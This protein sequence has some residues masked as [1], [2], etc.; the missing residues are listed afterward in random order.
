MFKQTLKTNTNKLLGNLKHSNH[1]KNQDV[2]HQEDQ[3]RLNVFIQMIRFHQ[4]ERGHALFMNV[5]T[6]GGHGRPHSWN[7]HVAY[8][9]NGG[10][11][12]LFILRAE[13]IENAKE[14]TFQWC[15]EAFMGER[16][17]QKVGS[18]FDQSVQT[19]FRQLFHKLGGSR[20]LQA[21]SLQGNR[22]RFTRWLAMMARLSKRNEKWMI[23]DVSAVFYEE[24]YQTRTPRH[25]SSNINFGCAF[26]LVPRFQIASCVQ[27]FHGS[28]L[29]Y[30][31][32]LQHL[33]GEGRLIHLFL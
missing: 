9:A 6:P 23:A 11:C 15:P 24:F 17:L 13:S 26:I 29:V 8:A 19:D 14:C 31:A 16:E 30:L 22:C 7:E 12:G 3:W 27:L 5:V 32:K 28:A 2:L 21:S 18:N 33:S 1:L 25:V 4:T 10:N 20:K